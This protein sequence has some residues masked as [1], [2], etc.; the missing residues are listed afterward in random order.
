MGV[1]LNFY[2]YY[3]VR[4]PFKEDFMYAYE[5]VE[6]DIEDTTSVLFDGMSGEYVIIGQ[7]LWDSGDARYAYAGSDNY[8]EMPLTPEFERENK[9]YLEKFF[10]ERLPAYS[11]YLEKDWSLIFVPHFH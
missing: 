2:A 3:G 9:Q 6:K 8:K 7:R 1:N 5:E 11:H 4:L 10:K